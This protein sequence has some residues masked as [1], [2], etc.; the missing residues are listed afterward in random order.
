MARPN[1]IFVLIRD[2]AWQHKGD[3]SSCNPGTKHPPMCVRHLNTDK[4]HSSPGQG[5]SGRGHDDGMGTRAKRGGW[6]GFARLTIAIV[7][8]A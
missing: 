3:S 8:V 4:K 5:Q 1:Y 7:T 2:S 6:A